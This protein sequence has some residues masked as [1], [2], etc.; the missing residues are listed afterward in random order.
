VAGCGLLI[1]AA[2]GTAAAAPVAHSSGHSDPVTAYVANGSSDTVTPVDTA[3]NTALSPIAVGGNAGALAITPNGK[4]AYVCTGLDAVTP[5]RTA[6]NTA[7]S[8]ITVGGPS[9]IAITPSGATAYVTS[10]LPGTVTPIET[11]T[12]TALPAISAQP[13]PYAIAIATV[14]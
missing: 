11:A 13:N 14:P 5:I 12:N 2:S 4:T 1:F 8:P 3:T 7:L 10:D 6:T 9:Q